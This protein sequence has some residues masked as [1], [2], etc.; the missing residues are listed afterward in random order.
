MAVRVVVEFES[1][2]D[3]KRFVKGMMNDDIVITENVLASDGQYS[4]AYNVV[5]AIVTAAYKK[6]TKFCEPDDGHRGR[7]RTTGWTRGRKYG[8]WVCGVCGK[9][10]KKWATGDIW[11]YSMGYNLLP[12]EVSDLDRGVRSTVEWTAEE[13]GVEATTPKDD[14]NG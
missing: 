11:Q 14:D 3:A 5:K 7:K 6:P 9:P 4:L 8:W 2:D 13:L 12:P 10:T 1:D